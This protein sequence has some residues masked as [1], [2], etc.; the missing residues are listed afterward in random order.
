MGV[1]LTSANEMYGPITT[2]W[3]NNRVAKRIPWSAF[4]LSINDWERV[5]DTHD[6]LRV[7][8]LS[9]RF[10]Q[11]L[12]VYLGFK[13]H[14]TILFSRK[15]THPLACPPCSR[16]ITIGLGEETRPTQVYSLQRC[17]HPWSWKAAKVFF[18]AWWKAQFCISAWYGFRS[19]FGDLCAH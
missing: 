12:T 10:G 17:S 6:I 3:H 2:L 13:L 9:S 4:M 11:R 18:M 19:L 8:F 16:G 14:P 5:V 15:T 1:F 7:G